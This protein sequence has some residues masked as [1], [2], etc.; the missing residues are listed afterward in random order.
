MPEVARPLRVGV[1]GE[2]TSDQA[3]VLDELAFSLYL[4]GRHFMAA[5]TAPDRLSALALGLLLVEQAI[6]AQSEI[7]SVQEDGPCVRVLTTDPFRVIV[8]RRGVITGCGG[9]VSQ[10]SERRL[11]PLPSIVP[12]QREDVFAAL[13]LVAAPPEG[14]FSAALRAG[15]GWSVRSDDLGLTTAFARIIGVR[16]TETVLHD[17]VIGAV[18]HR[19]TAELIRAAVVAGVPVLAS[20][21]PPT[22]LAVEFAERTGLT[23]CGQGGRGG[24]VCYTHPERLLL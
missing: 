10:I 2:T 1:D 15:D 9:A 14:L 18:S 4:N 3:R 20:T 13:D 8:P 24:F 21:G 6:R 19:V 17:R 7:E 12:V 22:G 23:L 16:A 5:M 11:P